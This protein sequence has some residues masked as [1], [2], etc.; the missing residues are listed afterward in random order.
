MPYV[1]SPPGR[2]K[3]YVCEPGYKVRTPC[4]TQQEVDDEM[5]LVKRTLARI[6]KV[7]PQLSVAKVSGKG[8]LEDQNDY[9]LIVNGFDNIHPGI[10]KYLLGIEKRGVKNPTLADLQHNLYEARVK[11][12]RITSKKKLAEFSEDEWIHRKRR[13]WR[14]APWGDMKARKLPAR[15]K[16]NPCEW[17]NS[18]RVARN[19]TQGNFEAYMGAFQA[20]W[21]QY[22]KEY[23]GV[24]PASPFVNEEYL[25]T[26]EQSHTKSYGRW[27][28]T[29][30]RRLAREED[31]WMKHKFR[32]S[33]Q[34][35]KDAHFWEMDAMILLLSECGGRKAS[36]ASLQ[37]KDIQKSVRDDG[38]VSMRIAKNGKGDK[39]N[40]I[41]LSEE[42]VATLDRLMPNAIEGYLFPVKPLR[43]KYKGVWTYPRW[44]SKNHKVMIKRAIDGGETRLQITSKP[45][46]SYRAFVATRL[47]IL[48]YSVQVIAAH[49]NNTVAVAQ[50]YI[51]RWKAEEEGMAVAKSLT[52]DALPE[53]ETTM[54]ERHLKALRKLNPGLKL[55]G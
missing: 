36:V 18:E 6:K 34:V 40:T 2:N 23:P 54:S 41:P 32:N 10:D 25:P 21:N 8:A 53:P 29:E 22:D 55:V 27:E 20:A 12:R 15:G 46:H 47:H 42:A 44:W 51:D 1:Q 33:R 13:C 28:I 37:V 30:H 17:L 45:V 26:P 5:Q 16:K 24:L 38:T 4:D 9:D 19:W 7:L 49:I 39:W 14:E 50:G 35:V 43:G 11:G 48:G 31:S 3:R 52:D